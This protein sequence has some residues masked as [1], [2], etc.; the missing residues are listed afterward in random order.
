MSLITQKNLLLTGAGFSANF[1]GLLAREMWSKIL[2]NPKMD[3]IPEIRKLLKKNFDFESVYSD[4]KNSTVYPESDKKIF[5]DIVL[6]SYSLMDNALKNYSIGGFT[7]SNFFLGN[8]LSWMGNFAGIGSEVGA[9]F[10]LNQDL[11]IER[12]TKAIPLGFRT[13]QNRDYTDSIQ[14][15]QLNS[16]VQIKLPDDTSLEDYKS[17]FLPSNVSFCFVKLHGSIGWLSHDGHS[18]L[19]LGTNKLEDINKEPLLKWY[20][21]IFKEAISRPGVRLFVLGYSF[22]DSHINDL[23][24]KAI[25][26]YGLEFYIISPEQPES[27]K[28]RMEGKNNGIYEVLPT[29]KIWDA[30]RGYFPYSLKDIFPQNQQETGVFLDIKK[31]MSKA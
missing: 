26:E 6:E 31:C 5:Q 25:D 4:V 28:K 18:Q 17:K 10:T 27:F 30:V 15:G 23:I 8:I 24:L 13:P 16:K 20:F 21:E 14:M 3:Q 11:L 9:H 29:I 2:S 12:E 7:K 22:R 1:G 19:I